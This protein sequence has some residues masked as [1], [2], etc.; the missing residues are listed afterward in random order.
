MATRETDTDNI[1]RGPERTVRGRLRWPDLVR[2]AL[3]QRWRYRDRPQHRCCQDHNERGHR[4]FQQ[5]LPQPKLVRLVGAFVAAMVAPD[6]VDERERR[7]Q[8]AH[9]GETRAADRD[10]IL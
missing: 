10:L 2:E 6:A 1:L 3:R 8:I 7:F 4:L 9:C 5:G